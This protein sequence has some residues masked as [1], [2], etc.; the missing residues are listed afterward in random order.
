MSFTKST[1]DISVHQKLG[2]YPNQDNGMT[3]DELKKKFDYPAETL[4]K[5]LNKIVEELE[6]ENATQSIGANKL[7]EN[8]ET[9]NNVQAKLDKIY[10]ATKD[11]TL[12]QIPDGTITEEKLDGEYANSLAKKEN[13]GLMYLSGVYNTPLCENVQPI[14]YSSPA[15]TSE[16]TQGYTITLEN[17]GTEN[18][19]DIYTMLGGDGE[20]YIYGNDNSSGYY[21]ATINI[22]FPEY[23]KLESIYLKSGLYLSDTIVEMKIKISENDIDYVS[24]DCNYKEDY[25]YEITSDT[26]YYKYIQITVENTGSPMIYNSIQLHGKILKDIQ[27]LIITTP[28]LTSENRQGYTVTIGKNGSTN[29]GTIT[30][31][32]T[33]LGGNGNES[34]YAIYDN[35]WLIIEF[36]NYFKM[37]EYKIAASSNYGV[38]IY[39]SNDG[40][41][42]TKISEL[43]LSSKKYE[44]ITL[45]NN[46]FYKYYKIQGTNPNYYNDLY[47]SMYFKGQMIDELVSNS[48]IIT[49]NNKNK[50]LNDY[51]DGMIVRLKMPSNYFEGLN[52]PSQLKIYNLEYKKI[53]KDLKPNKYYTLVYKNSEFVHESEV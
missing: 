27:P 29:I 46:S 47:N 12:G 34:F 41:E 32:Y 39:G 10:Q 25:L 31:F 21:V 6:N 5:D 48:L 2:D 7:D 11:V 20:S 1:T 4:Q 42:Y 16:N 17:C 35:T 37:T 36:P 30:D 43:E 49:D 23:V 50:I 28:S 8:D 52:L 40:Q 45:N 14:D 38:A 53:P 15:L 22:T 9:E 26:N 13:L 33:M 19:K 24:V 3:A 44:F 51:I 18:I